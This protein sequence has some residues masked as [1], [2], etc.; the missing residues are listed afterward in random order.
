MSIK[1]PVNK[2]EK[3]IDELCPDG[4]EFRALGEIGRRNKGVNI[5]AT[6]M[7]EIHQENAPIKIFAGGR[8]VA[9]IPY[10]AIPSKNIIHDPSIIVK[11]RG[12]IGFEYYDQPFSHK[13]E[14][15]SYTINNPQANQK[16]V[17][18]YLLIQKERLQRLAKATSVKIPQLSVADT[19]NLPIP[20][21]PLTI[22]KEIVKILDNFTQLEAELETELEARKKQYE[23]YREA[24]LSFDDGVEFKALEEVANIKNGKDWKVLSIGDIPVYGT[25]G[26]MGY[27]DK[28]SY[29][30]PTVLIPRKGS[31]ENIFYLEEPFWNVDTIY[32]TEIDIKS[33]VPKYF[34][35]FIKTIDLK[36]LDTGSG[37][38]SLTQAILN[39]I[40]I[41]IPPL[42]EQKRIV[43]ILD[44]FDALVNDISVGLPAEISAR[45]KQYEYYRYQLLTFTPLDSFASNGV[46]SR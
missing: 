4:V 35:Y 42:P 37:R 22:Q 17:Y 25:G 11:S 43:A 18:Y 6:K 14:L 23:H 5:T 3:L 10:G 26:I 36:R 33:I 29:N 46:N 44:K 20:I 12:Y 40:K 27:V 28:F 16:F 32:Y 39:R 2:I 1:K 30:Q 15:W 7:K 31:I 21:P 41:P 45:K 38:P 34:Y 13:N 9:S 19:D 8:T 24:L